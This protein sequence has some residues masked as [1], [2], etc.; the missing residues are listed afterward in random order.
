MPLSKTDRQEARRFAAEFA[1]G[2]LQNTEVAIND[3]AQHLSD[4]QQK[5]VCAE[6]SRIAARIE[7]YRG[8]KEEA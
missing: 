4:E 2:I 1:S 6:L 8:I 3:G 5:E 7:R